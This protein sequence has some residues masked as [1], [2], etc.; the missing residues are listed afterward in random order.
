MSGM[1]LIL[2]W[3]CERLTLDAIHADATS[4]QVGHLPRLPLEE[5]GGFNK[6]ARVVR[7][8][9]LVQDACDPEKI[10]VGFSNL[11]VRDRLGRVEE[12]DEL[13][14]P[15]RHGAVTSADVFCCP[16]TIFR[17]A[18]GGEVGHG[19]ASSITFQD[20]YSTSPIAA[21]CFK[22]GQ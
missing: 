4:A 2:M 19:V 9:L 20:L 12:G 1:S 17:A 22:R 5:G 18:L 7:A 11:R 13:G 10:I 16:S 6:S 21:A 14:A 3:W 15:Y 8:L